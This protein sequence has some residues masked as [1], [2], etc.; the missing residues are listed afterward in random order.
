MLKDVP[1]LLVGMMLIGSVLTSCNQQ[2]KNGEF[3]QIPIEKKTNRYTT[4][5]YHMTVE[6]PVEQWDYNNV[7]YNYTDEVTAYYKRDWSPG[8]MH[9]AQE[10]HQRASSPEYQ[11]RR[12][13]LKISFE[14][15]T[16]PITNLHSYLF[17]VYVFTGGAN[18]TTTVKSFNFNEDGVIEARHLFRQLTRNERIELTR[19]LAGKALQQPDVFPKDMLMKGLGL[20][21]QSESHFDDAPKFEFRSNFTNFIILDEGVRFYFDMYRIAPRVAGTPYLFLSWKELSPYVME[22]FIKI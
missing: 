18:G 19:L 10:L 20:S 11:S 22:K 13:E 3:R 16:A 17:Y 7:L 6:Y 1:G 12:F 9:Y 5:F 14:K 8:G 2:S 4:D 15:F 21:I